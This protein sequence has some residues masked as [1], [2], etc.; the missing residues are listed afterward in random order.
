ME[1]SEVK[2][3]IDGLTIGMF[4]SRL[5]R[6]WIKTPFSLQGVKIETKEDI[7]KLRSYCSYVYVDVEKG[8]APNPRYWI[9]SSKPNTAATMFD[10][11]QQKSKPA[12]KDNE[13]TKL[14]KT[15]Y[16]VTSNMNDEIKSAKEACDKMGEGFSDL[17]GDLS[18]GRDI[19]LEAVTSGITDMVDSIVR[20][21]S[22]LSWIVH[23]KKHDE[24]TYSRALGT[25]VWCATFGRH[26]G[27]EKNTITEL[28]LGGLLLD[29]GKT[30]IPRELIYKLGLLDDDEEKQ[31][32]SHVDL[33]IKIL[34]RASANS[35]FAKLP[36][37]VLQ[38]VATHHERFD[39]SGYPQQ[40]SNEE[41]PLYGKM[42]GLVDSYDAMTS[43]RPYADKGP[44]PPHEAI[45]ELYGLRNVKFQGELVEQFIQAV[46]LY[47]TGSLVELNTGEVG[48]VISVNGLRR[49]RPIVMLLLDEEKKPV[50]QFR[51]INLSRMDDITV[52][53]GVSPDDFGIN[54][55]ELFL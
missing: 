39:S 31:I 47:P 44:R 9:L 16:Q 25:S 3:S 15:T 28:A 27:L 12:P 34:A 21:P 14:R 50:S 18:K 23:L 36:L 43:E 54:M 20:N 5:D 13:Y 22:A 42:A 41:I 32:H 45:G 49:L 4:V 30:K 11:E 48:A 7:D 17:L 37:N 52:V 6:P 26:L 40:L 8:T 53:K 38:M 33:G 19:D 46:G 55:K 35:P 29:I 1:L 51:H 24:Y 2:T 10:P